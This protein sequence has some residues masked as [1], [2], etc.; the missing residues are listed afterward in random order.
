M[1]MLGSSCFLITFSLIDIFI[2]SEDINACW[3]SAAGDGLPEMALG[4]R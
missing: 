4:G 1:A 2:N 3:N